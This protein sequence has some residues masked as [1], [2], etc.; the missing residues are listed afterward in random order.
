M[1]EFCIALPIALT[2]VAAAIPAGA[3]EAA[4]IGS[5][6][7]QGGCVD[8]TAEYMGCLN[9]GPPPDEAKAIA[10]ELIA[11]S[12]PRASTIPSATPSEQ[13]SVFADTSVTNLRPALHALVTIAH[14]RNTLDGATIGHMGVP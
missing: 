6:L 1:R 3:Q 9:Y 5:S 2:L 10:R 4:P 8:L 13:Q 12:Q 7:H 14:D 11:H